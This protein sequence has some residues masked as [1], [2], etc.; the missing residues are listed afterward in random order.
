MESVR[1]V[2]LSWSREISEICPPV[3]EKQQEMF[4]LLNHL[5]NPLH[6]FGHDKLNVRKTRLNA[7]LL[8]G[9]VA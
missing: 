3:E 4:F 7:S 2:L 1:K 8:K 6:E 9:R 5:E